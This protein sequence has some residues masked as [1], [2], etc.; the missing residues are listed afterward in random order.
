MRQGDEIVLCE[1]IQLS[2]CGKAESR[3]FHNQEWELGGAGVMRRKPLL[4]RGCFVGMKGGREG[5]GSL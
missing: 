4:V 3:D 5:G 1:I 2:G